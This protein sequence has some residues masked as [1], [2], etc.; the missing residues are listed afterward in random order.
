MITKEM[1]EQ[2]LQEGKTQTIIAK[3]F[4]VWPSKISILIKKYGLESLRP[5]KRKKYKSTPLCKECGEV[6]I[7]QFFVTNLSMCKKCLP[8]I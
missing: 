5:I 7:K 1:L 8:T 4:N 6:N 2:L 3:Q